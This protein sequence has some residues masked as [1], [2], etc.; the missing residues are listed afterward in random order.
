MSTTA[1]IVRTLHLFH[2][3]GDVVEIRIPKL[4]EGR[5]TTTAAGYFDDFDAAAKAA[6]QHE[7]RAEG[8]YFTLN[9]INPRLLARSPNEITVKLSPTTSD[10]DV[11]RRRWLLVDVD[12]DRP[13]GLSST[14]DELHA[15]ERVADLVRAT[16][17]SWNWPQPVRAMSGNGWHLLYPIDLLNDEAST[18]TVK[19]LLGE[20]AALA[21]MPAIQGDGPRIKVDTAVFNA[22]R[23]TKLYGTLTGKGAEIDGNPHRRSRIVSVPEMVP[24]RGNHSET[25]VTA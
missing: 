19:S 13:A 21:E 16:V 4:R 6:L 15:A 7:D 5:W 23:I 14:D 25:E 12:P 9:Q 1:E 20:L 10:N 24:S 17:G 11:V 2:Q 8:I 18:A 3:P 22:A